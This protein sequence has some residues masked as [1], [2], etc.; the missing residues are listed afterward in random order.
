MLKY[1]AAVVFP[2]AAPESHVTNNFMLLFHVARSADS[3]AESQKWL[4][5]NDK[6][7]LAISLQM[8]FVKDEIE[9]KNIDPHRINP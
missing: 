2:A 5:K 8:E 6:L 9:D 7:M 1:F 3:Y 4:Q